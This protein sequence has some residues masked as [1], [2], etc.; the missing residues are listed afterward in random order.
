MAGSSGTGTAADEG[1]VLG[2]DLID[3]KRDLVGVTAG[4]ADT[5]VCDGSVEVAVE[6]GDGVVV[7]KGGAGLRADEPARALMTAGGL[8]ACV[9]VVG[10]GATG[11]G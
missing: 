11:A 8:A 7:G 2:R 3:D 5:E 4:L 6:R 10:D 1:A 9:G